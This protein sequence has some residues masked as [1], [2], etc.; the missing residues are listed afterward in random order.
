M[1]GSK[2]IFASNNQ[3]KVKEIQA[4]VGEKFELLSLRDVNCNEDI[5]ETASTLMGNAVLK[6]E[7]I[8]NKFQIDCFADDTGLMVESLNG[9]PGVYSARYAGP[10]KNSE[11]NIELLLKNLENSKN[12]KAKFQTAICLILNGKQHH[13]IGEIQGTITSEKFGS[14]GFGYDPIFLPDCYPQTF[15][16]MPLDLK[17]KISHRAKAMLQLIEFL[18]Q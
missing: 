7:Y 11:D 5:P 10:Q 16:E 13:F 9:D 18:T 6:A 12:R 15:A 17:N 14:D 8:Y 2:L 1:I 4:L 3:N